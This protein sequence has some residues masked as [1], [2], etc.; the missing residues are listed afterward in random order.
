LQG[1]VLVGVAIDA[2][3]VAVPFVVGLA[4]TS[5]YGLLVDDSVLL[6]VTDDVRRVAA[7]IWLPVMS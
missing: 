6:R 4:P 3:A 1:W 5:W 2:V 7:D